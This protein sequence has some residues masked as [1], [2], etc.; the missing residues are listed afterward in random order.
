MVSGDI[1]AAAAPRPPGRPRLYEPDAERDLILAS[2]LDVLRRNRGEEATVANVLH[3]AGL[4]TRAFYRHFQTKEDVMRALYERDAR[5]FGAHLK[6]RVDSARDPDEALGVW[7]YEMLGLAY[8]RRRAER[9]SALSSP[10]VLRAVAGTGAQQ[11]GSDLLEQPLRSVLE[12]GM[13][14]VWFTTTRPDLD[15]R[16]IR[17]I[18]F[19]AINW[20]RSGDIKLSRREAADYILGFSRAGLGAPS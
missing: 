9:V 8:D 1:S 18:T 5:S 15:I 13:A 17:A 7:V 2:A 11:L 19:E 6:R 14:G 16:T 10:M 20:V 12:Q 3:E 4:S